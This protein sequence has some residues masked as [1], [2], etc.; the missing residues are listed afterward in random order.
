MNFLSRDLYVG[1]EP[2]RSDMDMTGWVHLLLVVLL[3]LVLVGSVVA[4]GG[5]FQPWPLP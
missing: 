2:P 1:P 3:A 4:L 5:S